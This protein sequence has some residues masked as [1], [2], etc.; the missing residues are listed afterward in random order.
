MPLRIFSAIRSAFSASICSAA[1]LD[2]RD[3]VPLPEDTARDAFRIERIEPVELLANTEELDRQAGDRAHG[4]RS[5]AAA[6]T[7]HPGQDKA[8][9][10]QAL[11]EAPRGFDRVLTGQGVGNEQCFLRLGDLC[12]LRRLGHHLF[13]D[14]GPAGGI[15]EENIIAANLGSV[16]RAP[17]DVCRQLALHDR[18]R[19]DIV[20]AL[21]CQDGQ[22][23]HGR[24]AA[25]VE[26]GEQ[27][28]LA[29]LLRQTLGQLA[30]RGR[31]TRTLQ[32][33]H[34][35]DGWRRINAQAGV[36]VFPAQHVDQA[37]IDDLDDLLARLHGADDF[38]AHGAGLHLGDEVLDHGQRDVRFQQRNTDFAQRF[39]HILFG[40]RTAPRQIVE[41]AAEP[42]A[43]G[44]KHRVTPYA[45]C[46]NRPDMGADWVQRKD[47]EPR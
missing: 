29:A 25:H 11:M 16:E 7:I 38:L 19:A 8:G 41:Y 13:V 44:V 5:A 42:F 6:V 10:R 14:A 32:A 21:V 37:V 3:N 40:E 9:Q 26:R 20:A 18:Q 34:H 33:R 4:E 12:D 35:H 27:D 1:F 39:G 45:V 15:E 28:F 36:G 17:R 2:Q 31:F 46:Q 30:G 47:Q 23:F 43:E 22:L 24:R